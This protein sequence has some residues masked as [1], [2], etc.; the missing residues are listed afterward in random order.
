[1]QRIFWHIKYFGTSITA[2]PHH[3]GPCRQPKL[4]QHG[5]LGSSHMVKTQLTADS[6]VVRFDMGFLDLAVFNHKSI[7]LTARLAEDG[8]AVKVEVERLGEFAVRIC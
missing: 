3:Q 1:M 2:S 7:S 8:S 6:G 4:N 5:Q